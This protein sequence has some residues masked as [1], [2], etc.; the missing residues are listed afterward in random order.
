MRIHTPEISFVL[1]VYNGEKYLKEAIDS[2]LRQDFE[3]FELILVDDGSTDGTLA[4][5][6]KYEEQDF[7]CR[8]FSGPNRGII[9]SRNLGI[10]HAGSDFIALMDADD[11]CMPSRISTQLKYLLAHPECVAVGSKVQLIDPSGRPLKTLLFA[12]HHLDIDGA[13]LSGH[14][15]A[16][17]NPSA[18]IRKEAIVEVGLYQEEFRYAE[19]LDLFLRLAEVGQLANLPDILLQYRQHTSSIGYK[20][21]AEQRASA[22]KAVAS[23]CKRRGLPIATE[24]K[25]YSPPP[26]RTSQFD[27][28][29]KWAWWA[30][31]GGNTATARH[32]GWL[33]IRANPFKS[34]NLR[35]LW[36]IIRGR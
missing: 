18:L 8:V 13:H 23:A 19:D 17:I 3:N 22:D 9:A 20:H 14:G 36:C 4:I 10:A 12:T 11:I 26:V 29:N 32:Y 1:C 27:I 35:L 30:F 25:T 24:E 16:I 5:L 33:A 28:Y 7:R 31:N 2:V 21:A 15:G 6:Q 34:S